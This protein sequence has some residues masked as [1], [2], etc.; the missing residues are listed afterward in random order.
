MQ[1]KVLIWQHSQKMPKE[2]E[3]LELTSSQRVYDLKPEQDWGRIP[4]QAAEYKSTQTSLHL[5]SRL[6]L[7]P[8]VTVNSSKSC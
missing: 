7:R 5:Q 8:G 2:E 6:S 4:G 1:S 3:E